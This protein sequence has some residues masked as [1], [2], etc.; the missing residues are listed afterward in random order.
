MN[1]ITILTKVASKAITATAY[2]LIGADVVK[3]NFN[4]KENAIKTAKKIAVTT[5]AY[6]L[7]GADKVKSTTIQV[8]ADAKDAVSKR[9]AEILAKRK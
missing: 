5:A 7:I 9:K 8:V 4:N 1:A 2:G 3:A 6:T